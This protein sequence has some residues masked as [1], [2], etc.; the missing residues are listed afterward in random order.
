MPTDQ[1]RP[2]SQ[3]KPLNPKK[4]AI[5]TARKRE[6]RGRIYLAIVV[7]VIVAVGVGWYV[8]SSAQAPPPDFAIAAPTGVTIHAGNPV[9][10]R[11]NVTAV[12]NF[13]GTVQLSATASA[14]LTATISPA[15]ITGSGIATLAMSAKS[16]G[17]YTVTVTGTSGSLKHS[18]TPVV[19]TP[20]FATLNTSNGTIVVEL[21]R[22]QAPKTVN[23]FVSLAQSAFYSNLVW[24][25]IVQGFVIQTGDPTTKD[26]GGNRNTWGQNGSSQT[27]PLE[28]DPSLHNNLGYLGMAR[29]TD[30]NSGSSQFYINLANNNSLDGKYTVFGKV[31]A[32]MDVANTIAKTPVYTDQNSPLYDQPINPVYLVSVTISSG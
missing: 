7:I 30:V 18:I 14:G 23:N 13:G 1:K 19:E 10:S 6:S 3:K 29:S 4:R 12:N 9:T 32:G 16:N 25:R 22:A 24:H 2:N 28:I 21:Y 26:G 31:I 11:V 15:N 17:T 5:Q 8:Y 27:V 20:V